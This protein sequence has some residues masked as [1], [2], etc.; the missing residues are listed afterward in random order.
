MSEHILARSKISRGLIGVL[1]LATAGCS[2]GAKSSNCQSFNEQI[3]TGIAHTQ[4]V[5]TDTIDNGIYAYLI[6]NNMGDYNC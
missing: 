2:S 1:S 5:E 4:V 6:T 3:E